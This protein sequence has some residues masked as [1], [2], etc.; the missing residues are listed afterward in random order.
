MQSPGHADL[1]NAAVF[2]H[3][4]TALLAF[5]V[6][7]AWPIALRATAARPV[8]ERQSLY[9]LGAL[10][11]RRIV[12]PAMAIVLI[13]GVYLTSARWSFSA[14]WINMSMTL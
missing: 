4:A 8:P 1:Y 9:A 7:L 6:V 3:I 11:H 2:V 14:T 5:G 12:T 13:A 10:A